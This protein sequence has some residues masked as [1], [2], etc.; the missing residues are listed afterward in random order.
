MRKPI[1]IWFQDEA[2]IGQKNGLVRQWARRGTRP[3]Q[4]AD[5]RYESAYLFGAIC[6]ARGT[7]AAL[8][9]PFADTQAMQLHL[10]EIARTV[11]R[12]AHAALLLDRAGWHTTGALNIPKNITII[13]GAEPRRKHLA[14]SAPDLAL[15]PRLQHL[16]G[17]HRGRLR[18]LAQAHRPAPNHHIDRLA[19]MGTRRSKV[20]ALGITASLTQAGCGRRSRFCRA[21]PSPA[22]RRPH[23]PSR[24]APPQG[25]NTT[26]RW[27]EHAAR[28]P[29]TVPELPQD[30]RPAAAPRRA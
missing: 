12:G 10:D 19:R 7:G 1:E 30:G 25:R 2:R 29:R 23:R 11:K 6:P 14:V 20:K 24:G 22:E 28:L 13:P 16:R 18:R 9:L 5:Q 21:R 17:D 26:S 3:R 27:R 4:P 8:A 15:E